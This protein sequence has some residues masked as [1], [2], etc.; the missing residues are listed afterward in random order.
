[1][2]ENKGFHWCYFTPISG[3]FPAFFGKDSLTF[4]Q[5]SVGNSHEICPRLFENAIHVATTSWELKGPGAG[6]T[7]SMPRKS[8]EEIRPYISGSSRDH[9][10]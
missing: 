4:H 5:H 6:P 8:P 10:G 7:P 2:S 9:G 1:M 3:D